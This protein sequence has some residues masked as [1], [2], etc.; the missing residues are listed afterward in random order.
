[1]E[2]PAGP[3]LPLVQ[4]VHP[5]LHDPMRKR[6]FS[7]QGRNGSFEAR[8]AILHFGGFAIHRKHRQV[9]DPRPRYIGFAGSNRCDQDNP[10]DGQQRSLE[11][12]CIAGSFHAAPAAI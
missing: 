8:P 1:M 5:D 11:S 4:V 3:K 2:A 12:T 9:R 10:A 6:H 7:T